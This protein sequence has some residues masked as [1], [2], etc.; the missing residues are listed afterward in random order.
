MA[1]NLT[2]ILKM[3]HAEF[4]DWIETFNKYA[5]INYT[6][7]GRHAIDVTTLSIEHRTMNRI[8]S[9]VLALLL[10]PT[11]QSA[12]EIDDILLHIIDAGFARWRSSTFCASD[13]EYITVAIINV[14]KLYA[15]SVCNTTH[16]T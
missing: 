11:L 6:M 3:E 1:C 8:V 15:S 9:I 7:L 14:A 2:E 12:L 13:Q 4:C 10:D 5:F 16:L